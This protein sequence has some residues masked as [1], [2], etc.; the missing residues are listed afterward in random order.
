MPYWTDSSEGSDSGI[1][2][3]GRQPVP[4]APSL[5]SFVLTLGGTGF[6]MLRGKFKSP[7]ETNQDGGGGT[8]Q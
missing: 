6:K 5:H 2:Q 3:G 7:T 8:P 4:K 1:A